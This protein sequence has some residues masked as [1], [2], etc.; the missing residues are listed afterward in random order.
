MALVPTV[1]ASDSPH[2]PIT[3]L[4]QMKTTILNSLLTYFDAGYVI[5]YSVF[6]AVAEELS[7]DYNTVVK[8]WTDYRESQYR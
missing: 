4:K 1:L 7:V 6:E 8:V 5:H 3:I 2:K